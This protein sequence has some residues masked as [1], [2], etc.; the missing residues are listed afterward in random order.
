MHDIINPK[1][2]NAL[3][4]ELNMA[5][6]DPAQIEVLFASLPRPYGQSLVAGLEQREPSIVR[7]FREWTITLGLHERILATISNKVALSNVYAACKLNTSSLIADQLASAEQGDANAKGF[8]RDHLAAGFLHIRDHG[9]ASLLNI[10]GA[11]GAASGSTGQIRRDN[12]VP[13]DSMPPPEQA[14]RDT[15]SAVR[16]RGPGPNSRE[17]EAPARQAQ[18]SPAPR[19]EGSPAGRGYQ[20]REERHP[21][22]GRDSGLADRRVVDH[23]TRER[24]QT[25]QGNA[26]RVP[27]ESRYDQKAC[28]GRDTAIQFE[29]CVNNQG[30]NYTVNIAIA[31]ATGGSTRGGVNWNDKIIMMCT[32]KEVQLILAVVRGFLPKVRFA[33][34]GMGNDKWMEV[35]ETSE[36]YAGAIR[37]T[38]ARKDETRRV[39]VGP[40]DVGEVMSLFFRT[41]QDQLKQQDG[42]LVD[43]AIRRAADLHMKQQANKPQRPQGGSGANPNGRNSYADRRHG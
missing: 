15:T 30:T 1:R 43:L 29:R 19:Q 41:A 6:L 9:L 21:A 38:I 34:H 25:G 42:Y 31:K 37:F 39:N 35:E 27:E 5:T 10:G 18:A 13:I 12:A 26:P 23:P 17:R 4:D 33:G 40:D 16:Q 22:Q 36:Q 28:F 3:L 32:P 8:L 7:Q 24:Q 20:P 14:E 2:L 11:G